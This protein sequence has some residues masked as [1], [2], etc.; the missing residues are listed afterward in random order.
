MQWTC[1]AFLNEYK[2]EIAAAV[3]AVICKIV[4]RNCVA[5]CLFL[6]TRKFTRKLCSHVPFKLVLEIANE[7][8]H[9]RLYYLPEILF[10]L[11]VNILYDY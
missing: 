8:F 3:V 6:F 9:F 11:L 7:S 1:M 2:I 4:T 5:V 10:V